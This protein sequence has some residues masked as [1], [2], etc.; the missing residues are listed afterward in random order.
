MSNNTFRALFGLNREDG[1]YGKDHLGTHTESYP[2]SEVWRTY[3]VLGLKYD[4][5]KPSLDLS[6]K[7]FYQSHLC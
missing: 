1:G 2:L 6:T 4:G 7:R 5:T 3:D